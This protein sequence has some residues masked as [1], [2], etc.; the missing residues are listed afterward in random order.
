[1]K[2]H[3]LQTKISKKFN[4]RWNIVNHQY[5]T[6]VESD[7]KFGPFKLEA[8]FHSTSYMQQ[9]SVRVLEN[10]VQ[11]NTGNIGRN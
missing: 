9:I 7:M 1:M 5:R 3:Q 10:S 4:V 2:S 6:F 8:K 11:R